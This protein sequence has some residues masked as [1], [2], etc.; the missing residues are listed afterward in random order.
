MPFH[1]KKLKIDEYVMHPIFFF[2]N[3]IQKAMKV[4][5]HAYNLNIL[6]FITFDI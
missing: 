2:E 6:M 3:D 5:I 4:F 1:T